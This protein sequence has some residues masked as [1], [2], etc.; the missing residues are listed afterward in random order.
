MA[1]ITATVG[2]DLSKVISKFAPGWKVAKCGEDMNPGLH[3]EWAGKKNVLMTHPLSRSVGCV[4]SKKVK[5]PDGQKTKLRLLVGHHP[6]GDWTLLVKADGKELLKK[7]VGKE[8][9]D[10]GWMQADVDLS[11]YAG[12]EIKLELENKASDWRWEAGYWAEI[13]LISE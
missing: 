1:K 5:I 7:S 12:K 13:E 6:D 10:D 8:T 2:K 4:L 9:A 3:A 11:K